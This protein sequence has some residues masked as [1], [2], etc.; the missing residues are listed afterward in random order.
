MKNVPSNVLAETNFVLFK[1]KD[2]RKY[3]PFHQQIA[4]GEF[5]GGEFKVLASL[6][7]DALFI[8]IDGNIWTL[9]TQKVVNS[10]LGNLSLFL[11]GE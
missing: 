2:E 10:F 1:K 6:T 4:E 9:S 7:N 8:E 3:L 5:E 11:E